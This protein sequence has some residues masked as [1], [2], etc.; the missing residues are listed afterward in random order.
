[1][2]REKQA[3]V[4][5]LRANGMMCHLLEALERGEDIGHYGRLVF[6]IVARHFLEHDTICSLL[7][8]ERGFTEEEAAALCAQVENRTATTL[9]GARRSASGNASRT[10][11]SVLPVTIPTDAISIAI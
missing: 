10:F 1:M 6:V 4:E 5:T 2:T 3:G 7:A 8:N 9:R 11:R